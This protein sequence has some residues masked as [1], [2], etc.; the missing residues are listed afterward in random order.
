[1]ASVLD[2]V[3]VLERITITKEALEVR[4]IR[5]LFVVHCLFYLSFTAHQNKIS[6]D[7]FLQTR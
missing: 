5:K 1:M 7:A 3:S 2:I 6:F 4:E